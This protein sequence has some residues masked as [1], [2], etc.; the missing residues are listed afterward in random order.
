M[1]WRDLALAAD[2]PAAGADHVADRADPAASRS[3]PA[4]PGGSASGR[5]W[6]R[7]AGST[8]GSWRSARPSGSSSGSRRSPRPAA[9][10]LDHAAAELRR[11]ERDLHDGAQAR[12]AGLGMTL[13][14]AA[15]LLERD[16]EGARKML[17]EAR[18]TSSAAL[19]DLRDVVHGIH[20]P[21][22]AD[23]GL[24]AAIEALALDLAVP[25]R[26]DRRGSGR[27]AGAGRVRDLLHGRGVPGQ[28]RQARRRSAGLGRAGEP[29]RRCSRWSSAT[30]AGAA[31]TRR[32]GTGMRGVARRLAAFDGTMTVSSPIGGPTLVTLEV[33]CG[34]SSPRTTPSSG[35]A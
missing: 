19:G 34:S 9:E 27:A 1:T 10:S 18:Q 32:R 29:A 13:G 3:S 30:T 24:K 28:R 31:P 22:L 6:W 35:T 33:P 26:G 25:G 7:A 11:I 4:S 17:T 8:G 14:M 20:P 23:R 16:P 2:R 15:E 12:L 21:V 5:S